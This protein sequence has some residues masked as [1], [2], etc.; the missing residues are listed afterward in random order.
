MNVHKEVNKLF[1]YEMTEKAFLDVWEEFGKPKEIK[2][3]QESYKFLRRLHDVTKGL[4]IVDHFSFTNYDHVD[5]I[6]MDESYIAIYWKNFKYKEVDDMT[7]QIFGNATYIYSLCKINK[8]LFVEKNNHLFILV[9]PI[10]LLDSEFKKHFKIK[11]LPKNH[12]HVIDNQEDFT[13]E[14]RFLQDN[15]IHRCFSHNLPFFSFLLQ[16]KQNCASSGYSRALLLSST[17]VEVKSRLDRVKSKLNDLK[18]VSNQDSIC[19][20]GNTLRRVL[21]YLLKYYICYK[22]ISLP[23]NNYGHNMLGALSK[24]L[25]DKDEVLNNL[26]DAKTKQIANELSHDVGKVFTYNDI[27]NFYLKVQDIFKHIKTEIS[28]TK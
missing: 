4:F 19:E 18:K 23:N 22:E 16:P 7:R 9:M 11:K 1:D 3:S 28:K 10:V 6:C 20:L 8:L 25:K 5:D 15:E 26:I 21:E 27:Y 14:Y 24:A 13:T 12:Y 2:G 17:I